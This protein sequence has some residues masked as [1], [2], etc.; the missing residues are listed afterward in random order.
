M[1]GRHR[2]NTDW[3]MQQ[4]TDAQG[5][6]PLI[7][8]QI[9]GA[10]WRKTD[11]TPLCQHSS[12][13]RLWLRLILSYVL[14]NLSAMETRYLSHL[15]TFSDSY[16]RHFSLGFI[17]QVWEYNCT[18]LRPRGLIWTCL[19][20]NKNQRAELGQFILSFQTW[21]TLMCDGL[22][23]ENNKRKNDMDLKD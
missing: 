12:L 9:D 4:V 20:L 23:L 10:Q 11:P 16:P 15:W 17:F 6:S 13:F 8:A 3:M 7:N 22:S 14:P 5:E 21:M 1:V 2:G 19:P 18:T